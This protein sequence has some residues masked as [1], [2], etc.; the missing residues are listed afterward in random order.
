MRINII[1]PEFTHMKTIIFLQSLNQSLDEIKQ[2]VESINN[3]NRGVKFI[4]PIADKI[5]TVW[6]NGVQEKINSWYNYY[7]W[8]NNLKKHDDICLEEFNKNSLEIKKII[9]NEAK[10]INPKKIYVIGISQGGTI[11]IDTCLKL[12]FNIKKVICIDTIFLH[13]YFFEKYTK[14]NFVVF[15]SKNDTVYNPKFQDYCYSILED[16][17]CKVD[18][19]VFNF[20]HTEDIHFIIK[21]INSNIT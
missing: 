1:N 14:Q 15:Q 18:K 9:E 3:K 5:N 4:I 10:F 19:S 17:K 13:D 2:I 6:P 7:S 11:A 12:P 8:N 20:S 16:N 21:F